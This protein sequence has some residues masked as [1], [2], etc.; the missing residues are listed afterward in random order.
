MSGVAGKFGGELGLVSLFDVGHLLML[1]R[2]TGRLEVA[3]GSGRGTLLFLEGRI[4]NA[5]DEQHRE[6]EAVAYRI[7]GWTTGRFEFSPEPVG[8]TGSIE[9]GTE[10]L[11]LEAAR[12]Q[13]ESAN[14]PGEHR[15]EARVR[16]HQGALE[17]L[18][19]VFR[20]VTRETRR[21]GVPVPNAPGQA[22][23]ALGRAYERLVLRP[24]RPARLRVKGEWRESRDAALSIGDYEEFR[25]RLMGSPGSK[26]APTM[27]Q[28]T[29]F[30]TL[31]GERS[32]AVT[33]VSPGPRESLWLRPVELPA[34]DPDRLEGPGDLLEKALTVFPSLVLVGGPDPDAVSELLHAIMS[35]LLRRPLESVLLVSELPVYRHEEQ[36]GVLAECHPRDLP[37]AL[38]AALPKTLALDLDRR[39]PEHS[40]HSVTTLSRMMIGVTGRDAGEV[41]ARWKS[42]FA[43]GDR[44]LLEAHVARWPALLVMAQGAATSE[45]A[46]GYGVWKLDAPE[47]APRRAADRAAAER[48]ATDRDDRAA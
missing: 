40:L 14:A 43:P 18:R 39:L 48:Q 16:E 24:G 13:D 29:R 37:T 33:L 28:P 6:G 19:D 1:N 46:I 3:S 22:L 32:V 11:M 44:E 30:A 2:A 17:A 20:D 25:N 23:D 35:V 36:A 10:A 8:A 34:P 9:V 5:T 21:F 45:D 38:A 31:N 12:L 15:S 4:N 27:D 26:D 7:F 42:A 47:A 41:R